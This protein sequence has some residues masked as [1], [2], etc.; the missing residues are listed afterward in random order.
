VTVWVNT[1]QDTRMPLHGTFHSGGGPHAED[2]LRAYIEDREI[3]NT[4]MVV[5]LNKSPC[6]CTKRGDLPATGKGCAE[7]LAKLAEDRNLKFQILCRGIYQPSIKKADQASLQVL[8]WLRKTGRF[9][10][11]IEKQ[12]R[13]GDGKDEMQL[14]EQKGADLDEHGFLPLPATRS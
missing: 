2:K 11:S 3:K 12:P 7:M 8:E 9:A 4:T 1:D 5:Y 6:T 13:S 10:F 14:F